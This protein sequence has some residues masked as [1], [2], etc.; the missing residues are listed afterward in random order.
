MAVR[1]E[2]AKHESTGAPVPPASGD[3]SAR[4]AISRR[5]RAAM[6]E[7]RQ[8]GQAAA[9]LAGPAGASAESE[10]QRQQECKPLQGK[11]PG[12]TTGLPYFR[13]PY[14]N[15][16]F[17]TD[18]R[19]MQTLRDKIERYGKQHLLEHIKGWSGDHV[20]SCG[21]T[22]FLVPKEGVI[23][24]ADPA[25]EYLDEIWALANPGEEPPGALNTALREHC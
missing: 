11:I 14:S 12:R 15:L 18:S 6:E 1:Q 21:N 2:A 9:T 13:T 24:S 4:P 3:A 19:A 7:A 5:Q 8:H 20:Q 16:T 23:R 25:I 17:S 10:T 22:F